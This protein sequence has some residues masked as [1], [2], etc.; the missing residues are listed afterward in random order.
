MVIRDSLL[1]D[2]DVNDD[3]KKRRP[4]VKE[5]MPRLLS[6]NKKRDHPTRF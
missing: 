1:N 2:D 3:N 6:P 5:M 4:L